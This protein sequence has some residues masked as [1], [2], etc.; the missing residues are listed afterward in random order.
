MIKLID[1]NFGYYE[2]LFSNL[3]LEIRANQIT[4]LQGANG[5]G[6]TT[7][8]RLLSGLETK[9]SGK[10]LINN[11]PLSNL[12]AKEISQ[13][14][15]Y[16]KQE[17]VANTVAATPNEDLAIW[18][19]QF[20]RNLNEQYKHEREDVLAELMIGELLYTPF[21]E[22]SGGQIKRSAI[23]ALLLS[24]RKYWILD[25]PT[26]GLHQEIVDKLFSII[27]RR[28]QNGIGA[29]IITHK[30]EQFQTISDRILKIENETI[31][32]T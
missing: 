12:S 2:P 30:I 22:M 10:I 21:W 7:F 8:C 31:N 24:P 9:Y 16:L 14:L 4:I 27:E 1:L 25:E 19:N 3:N 23:A 11:E 15:I 18:Q 6:K 13:K 17:P 26:S 5:S 28:K 32:E 29:L 20:S